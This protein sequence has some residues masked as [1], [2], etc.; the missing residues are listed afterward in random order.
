MISFRNTAPTS[1]TLIGRQLERLGD[2]VHP[3]QA[4]T[5]AA[6]ASAATPKE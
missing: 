2:E 6:P 4:Y 3:S 1:M 5:I